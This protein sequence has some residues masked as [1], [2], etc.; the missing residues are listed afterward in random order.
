MPRRRRRTRVGSSGGRRKFL[1]GLFVGLLPIILAGGPA[2]GAIHGV[3][4]EALPGEG[5]PSSEAAP[6]DDFLRLNAEDARFMSRIFRER[7]HE[8]AYCGAVNDNTDPPVITVWMADT[9]QASREAVTFSTAN[10]PPDMDDV[11]LHTHPNGN[12]GLSLTD[13]QTIQRR[14]QTVT[15]VQ[16]GPLHTEP[17]ERLEQ[18]RCYR[19]TSPDESE[20]NLT[21]LRVLLYPGGAS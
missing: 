16:G 11:L 5:S 12:L 8:I 20:L 18:L 7:N 15:C 14:P 13:K 10:C 9:V 2:Q 3:V 19:Q 21:T 1:Y 17:G 4:D 6:M